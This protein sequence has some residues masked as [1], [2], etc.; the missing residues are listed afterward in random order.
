MK[1]RFCRA[2]TKE[3]LSL[4][5]EGTLAIAFEMCIA[6]VLASKRTYAF[7]DPI[8]PITVNWEIKYNSASSIEQDQDLKRC[9]GESLYQSALFLY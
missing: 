8:L 9:Q 4:K 1:I 7:T 3:P 2:R 5:N 6:T